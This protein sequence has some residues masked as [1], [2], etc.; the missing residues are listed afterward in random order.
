MPVSVDV[1]DVVRIAANFQWAAQDLFTNVYN[2]QVG[3]NDSTDD[4]DFMAQVTDFLEDAYLFINEDISDVV[5]YVNVEG[6]NVT[7]DVLLPPKAWPVLT[8]GG[9]ATQALPTQCSA[10]VYFRTLRPRTRASKFLPPYGE[11]QNG[12]GGLVEAAAVTRLQEYGDELVPGIA[13]VDVDAKYGAYNALL[14]R[15]TNVELAIVATRF[16]TQRRRRLGVGS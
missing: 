1:G 2:F 4:D 3:R 16:R 9:N 8:T 10:C 14:A 15:F 13:S 5:N 12:T 11:N 6:I 7:Q